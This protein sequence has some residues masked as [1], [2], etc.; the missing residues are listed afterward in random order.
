MYMYPK[1]SIYTTIME[2]GPERPS[3]LWF[4]GPNSIIEVYM[5]PLGIYI[6]IFI[7]IYLYICI[8][9]RKVDMNYQVQSV[10]LRLFGLR[11]PATD[12]RPVK[13]D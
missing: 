10:Y 7:F 3:L 12:A 2:L 5:D 1:G 13:K 8:L 11:R 4:W 9:N 6:Y